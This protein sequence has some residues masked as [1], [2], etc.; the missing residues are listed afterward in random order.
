MTLLACPACDLLHEVPD[1]APGRRARCRR[2]DT[3]IVSGQR[4]SLDRTLAMAVAVTVLIVFA[5]FFPFLSIS[6]LGLSNSATLI[7]IALV[8]MSGWTAPLTIAVALTIVGIPFLRA[9]ILVYALGPIRFGYP[10]PDKAAQAFRLSQALRPWAMAEIF[11]LGS[12]VA[13]VKIIDLAHV[14]FGAAFWAFCAATLII[15]FERNTTD[16]AAIWSLIDDM[17]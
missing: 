9:A 3:V 16:S 1:L 11:F 6:E 13:L 14:G 12:A 8:F 15:A 5:L 4:V 10:I 17:E 7:E 2:C